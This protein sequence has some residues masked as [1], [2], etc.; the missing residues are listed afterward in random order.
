ML[1]GVEKVRIHIQHQRDREL[2]GIYCSDLAEDNEQRKGASCFRP[3]Q[4]TLACHIEQSS[5]LTWIGLD[6]ELTDDI[7]IGLYIL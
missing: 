6:S 7:N 3:K 4:Q 5:S 2:Y 1:D